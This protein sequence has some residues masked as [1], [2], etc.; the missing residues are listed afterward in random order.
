MC[1]F[2]V[3]SDFILLVAFA[4]A[5]YFPTTVLFISE[6]AWSMIELS[7]L[8]GLQNVPNSKTSMKCSMEN[9]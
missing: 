8:R 2:P 3:E 4:F 6:K 5:F 9:I 1:R 7:E